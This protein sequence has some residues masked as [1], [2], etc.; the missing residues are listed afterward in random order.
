M[1]LK[2]FVALHMVP[3]W[4]RHRSLAVVGVDSWIAVR[5]KELERKHIPFSSLYTVNSLRSTFSSL[6]TMDTF[7]RHR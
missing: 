2:M 3:E 1:A 5:I 4:F 7:W 6:I